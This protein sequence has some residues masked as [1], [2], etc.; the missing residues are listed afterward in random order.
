M[1]DGDRKF[2][3]AARETWGRTLDY[4]NAAGRGGTDGA[5]AIGLWATINV[6]RLLDIAERQ[7]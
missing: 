5:I 2:I 7:S 3:R 4:A 6:D 1:S